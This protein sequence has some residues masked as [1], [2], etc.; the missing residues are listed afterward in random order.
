MA[1]IEELKE[2]GRMADERGDTE[3]LNQVLDLLEQMQGGQQPS[4]GMAG[5]LAETAVTLATGAIAAP[6][7][8]L[9]GLTQSAINTV[10]EGLGV[11]TQKYPSVFM[12][13]GDAV[14]AVQNL[15]TYKPQTREAQ[16]TLRTVGNVAKPVFDLL[17]NSRQALGDVG[18]DLGGPVAAAMMYTVPD[19]VIEMILPGVAGSI[20][21]TTSKAF[22]GSAEAAAKTA[23]AAGESAE[24]L[25]AVKSSV[26]TVVE[27][28]KKGNIEQIKEIVAADPKFFAAMDE[29]GI[30]TEPLA[31]YYTTNTGL[32][33][34]I[35]AL[36]ETVGSPLP[37]QSKAF[38]DAVTNKAD[39]LITKYGG[40]I[41]KADLSERFRSESLKTID[42][43]QEM[44]DDI[45]TIV[46]DVIPKSLEVQGAD[47]ITQLMKEMARDAGGADRIAPQL[48]QAYQWFVEDKA[49]GRL[50]TYEN[51]TQMR[52][53]IGETL[54]R[55]SDVYRNTETGILKRVYGALRRDQDAA[56]AQQ[57]PYLSG[58]S[59]A[60]D[61]LVQK[62]KL[63]EDATK[64]LLGNDLSKNLTGI[65]GAA[66]KNLASSNPSARQFAETLAAVPAPYR[67]PVVAT[68]LN[69]LFRGTGAGKNAFDATQFVKK[70]E[71]LSRH[72]VARDLLFE[73]LPKTA[74]QDLHNLY[75]LAKGISDAGMRQTGTGRI[76]SMFGDKAGFLRR[77]VSSSARASVSGATGLPLVGE[78]LSD[79][80]S[81]STPRSAKAAEMFADPIFANTIREAVKSGY[82]EGK[83]VTK[84]LEKQEAALMKSE[85]FQRWA[86]TLDQNEKADLAAYGAL[87]FILKSENEEEPQRGQN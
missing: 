82:I 37:A 76:L 29:L 16:R 66:T 53:D 18:Y 20:T 83:A 27:T 63:L 35:G 8:G 25:R 49:A 56:I 78:A 48:R 40:S 28:V 3:T 58:V 5:G 33:D 14:K 44:T 22:K 46:D 61:Q 52:R 19:A 34:V 17:E 79:L 24:Q 51:I 75:R 67:T 23:E 26:D 47:N 64:K 7:S 42:Y 31:S 62:R 15:F 85:K 87:Q 71:E 30:T 21:R 72:G 13:P 4:G 1:T 12:E 74:P 70:Y 45:Y 73:Y 32:R 39:D 57:A 80:I 86:D 9:V 6:V 41:D 59:K 60:A 50:P 77:M 11:D 43:L 81:R 54:S 38:I 69:D 84:Q 68:A 36:H 10:G 55:K 65:I 2:L